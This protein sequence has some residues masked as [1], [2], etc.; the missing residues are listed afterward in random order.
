MSTTDGTAPERAEQ[1]ATGWRTVVHV[2][3]S[4]TGDHGDFYGLAAEMVETLRSLGSL[5]TVL[6]R[7]VDRYDV[8]RALYDDSGTVD[9]RERLDLAVLELQDLSSALDTAVR[10]A[11]RFHSEI[12]HIGGGPDGAGDRR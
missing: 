1:A 4:A 8:G 9:A 5:S 12:G 10:Y 7:Q 3:Q 2:Q 6:A 11:S